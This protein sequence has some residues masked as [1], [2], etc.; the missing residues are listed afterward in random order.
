M[1]Q[2][3]AQEHV[4]DG[5]LVHAGAADQQRRDAEHAD[6]GVRGVGG[7]VA[8]VLQIDDHAEA[9]QHGGDD[10]GEYAGALDVDAGVT[11]H[12]HILSHGAHVLAQLGAPEPHD[13]KA[14]QCDDDEGENG[15]LDAAHA[16]GQGVVQ[17]L[18]HGQQAHGLADAVAAGQLDG[19]VDDGDDGAHHVQHH[20]LVQA[21][22]EEGD[23]VAGDHLAALGGVED[24]AA[25]QAHQRGDGDGEYAGQHHAGDAPDLP[26]G[27]QYQRDLAGHGPQGHAEVQA[28][29]RHDGDEQAQNQEDVAAHAGDDLVDEEHRREA[30]Q[31]DADGDDDDEHD[32]HAVGTQEAQQLLSGGGVAF[33]HYRFTSVLRVRA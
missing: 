6:L 2:H 24:L 33:L 3:H 22:G 13:G 1:E 5:G 15:Y 26:V 27:D 29:A 32:R 14:H 23:D 16:Q 20:Q 4:A 31:G 10:D 25:H 7:H 30:R 9:R 18:A 21:V 8:H 17:T 28:H 11:G 12:V 19:I